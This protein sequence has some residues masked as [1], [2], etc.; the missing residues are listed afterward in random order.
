[1]DPVGIMIIVIMV[2]AAVVMLADDNTHIRKK[3]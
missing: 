1:M 2:F 3:K